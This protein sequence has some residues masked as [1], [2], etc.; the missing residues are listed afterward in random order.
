[1]AHLMQEVNGLSNEQNLQRQ[2][3]K[4]E[5]AKVTCECKACIFYVKDEI[6]GVSV[7]VFSSEDYSW[8]C[9]EPLRTV[10]R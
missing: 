1:M 4:R 6:I 9:L 3:R 8:A 2:K 7:C 10:S 5:R